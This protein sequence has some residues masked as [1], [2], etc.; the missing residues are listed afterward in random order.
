MWAQWAT[1]GSRIGLA[2]VDHKGSAALWTLSR[3]GKV[4]GPLLQGLRG[5]E[6]YRDGRTVLYTRTGAD[7]GGLELRAADL[8]NGADSLLY[9]GWAREAHRS[10]PTAGSSPFSSPRV[11][12]T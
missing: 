6:F 10:P 1:D 4:T 5:F 9:R 3:D 2:T 11:T 7:G 8:E 12:S